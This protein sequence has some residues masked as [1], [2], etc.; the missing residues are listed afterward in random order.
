M[1]GTVS[2]VNTFNRRP[3]VGM[4]SPS[5]DITVAAGQNV[6]LAAD[7]FDP[8]GFVS[9]VRF[10]NGNTPLVTDTTF[11]FSFVMVNP[12]PGVYS[13][14][15][16]AVDN[17]GLQTTSAP[18]V[19]TVVSQTE[20]RLSAPSFSTEGF[21]FNYTADIGQRYVVE[22]TEGDGWGPFVPLSTNPAAASALETFV[23]RQPGRPARVY[24][25]F[26]QP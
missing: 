22:G 23:D 10:R 18:V 7:A 5:G 3:T 17:A 20:L 14:N 24:R 6:A 25:V 26:R 21:R 16:L 1:T 12:A 8:D 19:V 13:I 4:T 11:P 9:A 2:V 15:A